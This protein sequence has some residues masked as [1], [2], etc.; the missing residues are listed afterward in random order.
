MRSG[1]GN[2]RATT[3]GVSNSN[4]S[5]EVK[6]DIVKVKEEPEEEKKFEAGNHMEVDLVDMLGT[7]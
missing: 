2:K 1:P 5:E 3:N 7:N 6:D 4:P